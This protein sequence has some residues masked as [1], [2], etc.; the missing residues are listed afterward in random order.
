LL[1]IFTNLEIEDQHDL[2]IVSTYLTFGYCSFKTE[3]QANQD[4]GL[5][6]LVH[7]KFDK[8]LKFSQLFLHLS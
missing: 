3:Q 6:S 7:Q 4:L 1:F 8:T 2:D 5:L